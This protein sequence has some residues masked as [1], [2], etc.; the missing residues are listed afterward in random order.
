MIERVRQALEEQQPFSDRQVTLEWPGRESLLVDCLVSLHRDSATDT[1]LLLEFLVI[2]RH[3][4]IAREE[5]LVTQQTH[6][7]LLLRGLAHEIKNPLGGLR[8]AAQL[9]E[10]EVD[11]GGLQEYTSI[12]IREADRLLYLLDSMLAPVSTLRSDPVNIHDPLEHVRKILLADAR[13]QVTF[14]TDYD[15]SIPEQKTD[16]DRLTQV[17]L[18]IAINAVHAVGERGNIVFQTRVRNN[19][20]L[21]GTR[22]SLVT[23]VRIID[24][25]PG[26]AP[27]M[28]EQIFYPFV[29]GRHGGSGLGLSIAQQIINQLGGLIE[30]DSEPGKTIFTVLLPLEPA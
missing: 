17:L 27:Q 16:R 7:R 30:C 23:C 3:V 29:S 5:A 25:G 10:R 4:R 12:I 21:G 20:T 26:I 6:N 24:D 8:G 2:D 1:G 9:L 15:P 28:L 19:F 13:E 11:D 14:K 22:H 18:N